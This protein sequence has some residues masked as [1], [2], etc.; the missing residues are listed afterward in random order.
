VNS[1]AEGKDTR[2][3][4]ESEGG[5]LLVGTY[6]HS[7][8][9]KRRVAIPKQVREAIDPAREGTAFYLAPGV[10]DPCIW[11]FSEREFQRFVK[12]QLEPLVQ[13][14]SG[15]G[16]KDV[17]ALVRH[18]LGAA[19]RAEPDKQ[20]RILLSEK[21][22]KRAAIGREAAF[23]G[24]GSRIEIWEPAQLRERDDDQDFER[25]ARELFG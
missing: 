18:F 16:S 7:V 8:D 24:V 3:P 17:R 4:G 9:E 11:L 6:V 2:T 25:R 22:C 19:E 14:Q 21:L 1:G 12:N 20:G 13:Q 15:I 23:V 5:P 10:G